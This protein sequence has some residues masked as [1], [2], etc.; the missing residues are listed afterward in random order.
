MFSYLIV[1]MTARKT[2]VVYVCGCSGHETNVS[3][4]GMILFLVLV[5]LALEFGPVNLLI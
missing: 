3:V 1:G 2:C 5:V 4:L